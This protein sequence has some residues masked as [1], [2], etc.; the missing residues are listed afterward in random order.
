MKKDSQFYF[1]VTKIKNMNNLKTALL[2]NLRLLKP[3]DNIDQKL[4][5]L[6]YQLGEERTL[7]VALIYFKFLKR[8]FHIRFRKNQIIAVEVVVS[9]P[10]MQKKSDFE[11]KLYFEACHD[12]IINDFQCPVLSSVI[13]QDESYP[14]AHFIVMPVRDG[15]MAGAKVLGG[16]VEFN[17]R[18]QR[19]KDVVLSRF[20]DLHSIPESKSKRLSGR[21]LA[22]ISN[23]DIKVKDLLPLVRFFI[24][25]SPELCFSL[26]P[27]ELGGKSAFES[28]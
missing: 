27:K 10:N 19:F 14:H 1:G 8:Q 17:K 22:N 15:K 21:L 6:N 12:F 7:D 9:M 5:G 4:S 23:A 28:R 13:H 24:K 16:P 3:R 18:R 26:L 20:F 2:H 25:K 11:S